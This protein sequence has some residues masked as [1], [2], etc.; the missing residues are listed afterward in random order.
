MADDATNESDTAAKPEIKQEIA[1]SSNGRDITKPYVG[2]LELNDDAVLAARGG[3][4]EI[5]EEVLRDDQVY[6][7]F[8]QRRLSVVKREWQVDAGADDKQ[9]QMAAEFMR[10]MLFSP[11][12]EFDDKTNKMLY[13]LF[14]GYG[15]AEIIWAQD[16]RSYF[17]DQIKVRK[18][19]RFRYDRDGHLR[20]LTTQNMAT[21]ELM[22]DNKFWTWSVGA[23]NDDAPY[24]RGLGHWCYWPAFFKRN[25][26]KF[27]MIFMDK[28]GMPTAKGTYPPG[29]SDVDQKKLLEAVS[30]I[31]TDSGII[32]PDGMLIELIQAQGRGSA[33]YSQAYDKF[34]AAIAKVILSQTATTDGTP[35]KLGNDNEQMQVR[36]EVS[37]SDSDLLC[38]SFN[39][40]PVKWLTDWNF[41]G[42]VPP[43][44]YRSFEEEEDL[45]TAAETDTKIYN[46]G[47]APDAEYVNEKYGAHWKPREMTSPVP[48]GLPGAVTPP[49][50]AFAEGDAKSRDGIDA[51]VTELLKDWKDVWTP[52]IEQ[53]QAA[54]AKAKNFDEF[55][56]ALTAM[57]DKLDTKALGE[58]LTSVALQATGGG[59][60]GDVPKGMK[61]SA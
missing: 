3:G 16:G 44:V 43:R 10:E 22:P 38:A 35:G 51:A 50:P 27:W 14:Y 36:D 29:T 26:V 21:G 45:G 28:F 39:R 34:D 11:S 12:L 46:M 24:G 53:I 15:V 1:A 2:A 4:L 37:K 59:I 54:A 32:I 49:A 55:K 25:G 42:A 56:K 40:G 47:F 20:L 58:N 33:D 52:T 57:R 18:A 7:C 48:P 61:K 5:Y 6:S 30:A 9:S 17:I 60:L 23:D 19:R 41:P 13:T 8:Q 31:Q